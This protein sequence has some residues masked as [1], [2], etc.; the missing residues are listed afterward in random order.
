M[1]TL[2]AVPCMD[3]VPAQFAQSLALLQKVDECAIAFQMGSLI[4]NSRNNLATMAVNKGVDYIL[5]LDSDMMFPPDVL[6]RLLEDRDKGDIITG[7]Y[8]RRVQPF[9]PVLFSKLTIDDNGC[10]WEGYDDYPKEDCFEIAGCGFGCVLTP[11]NV[12]LD[13]LNKFDNMFAPIGGVGE[14]LSFCWRASQC[15]YKIIADPQVQCGHIG[16]YV[17]DREFYEAYKEGKNES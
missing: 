4:Y 2:I 17:I 11:V 12:F 1:K 15:G 5:W 16:H 8:Y 13:V 9:K 7:I 3:Q 6:K 10:S 14:D